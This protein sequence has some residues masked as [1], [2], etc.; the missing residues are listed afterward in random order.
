MIVLN[1][2]I[3]L[4]CYQ[5]MYMCIYNQGHSG[6]V[7]SLAFNSLGDSLVSGSFDHTVILWDVGNGKLVHS[8]NSCSLSIIPFLL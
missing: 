1:L 7:I 2:L 8:C 6:E 5:Y 4:V 3:A